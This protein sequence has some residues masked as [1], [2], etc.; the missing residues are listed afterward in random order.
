MSAWNHYEV[1]E[2]VAETDKAICVRLEDG[3]EDKWVPRSVLDDPDRLGKGD[4]NVT[5]T[6]KRWWAEKENMGDGV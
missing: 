5:L 6:V 3:D 2:V 4:V 1:E